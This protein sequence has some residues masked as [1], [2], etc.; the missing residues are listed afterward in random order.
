MQVTV[1]ATDTSGHTATATAT[2]TVDTVPAGPPPAGGY[3]QLV[4]VGGFATLPSDAEAAA[5]VHRSTW[6][7]RPENMLANHTVPPPPM[8]VAGYSGMQNHAALFGRV[9]GNFTGTTDEIIQW[10]AVK[11]GLPDEL[12]RAQVAA[13]SW[14]Y[15][16]LREADGSPSIGYGYGD[17]G[18]TDTGVPRWGPD[19]P[20]S[21]GLLQAKWSALKDRNAAGYDG[22]PWTEDAT[23]FAVDLV[24][25]VLRGCFEGWDT[26]LGGSYAAGDLWGCVGR[27]YAGEWH[28]APAEDYI[29]RVGALF[30]SKPWL[31][32]P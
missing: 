24:C 17:T 2:A 19:G 21:F 20:N 25:A 11:W 32:W 10:A 16:N 15:Q 8:V 23:A 27:W 18:H 3:F 4:P 22:W 26:W 9:T 30:A 7:P 1:T 31:S 28:T 13:E 29:D 12:L 6:E 5:L 14:W